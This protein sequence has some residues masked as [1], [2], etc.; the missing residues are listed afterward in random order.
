MRLAK[1]FLFI[2]IAAGLLAAC[3]TQ[4]AP[5]TLGPPGFLYG[6]LHGLIS[7]FALIGGFFTDVRVYAFPNSGWWYDF[8]F[9][10]GAGLLFG[11]AGREGE[12]YYV[13]GYAEGF[14]AG[15]KSGQNSNGKQYPAPP[16]GDV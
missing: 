3:A 9:I 4:P 10:I 5:S 8:G 16:K 6:L 7:P 14:A 11:A 15:K 2:L 1:T 12:K 13:A